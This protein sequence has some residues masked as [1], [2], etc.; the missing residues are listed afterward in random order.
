MLI[1]VYNIYI[2]V[3]MYVYRYRYTLI[4]MY[5]VGNG[6]PLQYSCL[7]I[8]G[9]EKPKATHLGQGKSSRSEESKSLIIRKP[10]ESHCCLALWFSQCEHGFK[11]SALRYIYQYTQDL[12]DKLMRLT[13]EEHYTKDCNCISKQ[14]KQ[15]KFKGFSLRKTC[16]RRDIYR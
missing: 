6:D 12:W 13:S 9:T 16:Q 3:Y 10:Q 14:L 8:S 11:T 5:G 4:H 1:H 7:R 15:C 2:Y